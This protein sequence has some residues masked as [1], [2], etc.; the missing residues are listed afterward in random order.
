ME[1]GLTQC[2][3]FSPLLRILHIHKKLSWTFEGKRLR[4]GNAAWVLRLIL[5]TR[6]IALQGL[7]AITEKLIC[8]QVPWVPCLAP[9]SWLALSR[10]WFSLKWMTFSAKSWVQI[11]NLITIR[12]KN[13]WLYKQLLGSS[14]ILY[15]MDYLLTAGAGD[16]NKESMDGLL[17]ER[18]RR[19]RSVSLLKLY[20]NLSLCIWEE[21]LQCSSTYQRSLRPN[22]STWR[23]AKQHLQGLNSLA[24]IFKLTLNVSQTKEKGS[25]V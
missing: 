18:G 17:G 15:S 12:L 20:A 14:S 8:N 6:S 4:V 13:H 22:S 7:R 10:R 3:F 11:R 19:W 25:E 2:S 5:R 1:K 21:A 24:F 9:T 23:E 16:L